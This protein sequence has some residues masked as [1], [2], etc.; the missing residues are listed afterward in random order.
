MA[1]DPTLD[2]SPAVRLELRHGGGRPVTYDVVGGE[3]L[4]GSVPGCDLRLSGTNLPPV[5]CVVSRHADGPHLRKLAPTLPLLLNGQPVQAAALRDGDTVTLGTLAIVVRVDV[6]AALTGGI[7]FEPVAAAPLPS[8]D[9]ERAELDKQRRQFEQQAADLEAD[10]AL[11]YR[12]REDIEREC[13]SREAQI[14]DLARQQDETDKVRNELTDLRRDL[15]ARYQE[16]RDR[17]AGLQQSVQTAARKVQEAKRTFEAEK[18]KAAPRLAELDRREQALADTREELELAKRAA[19]DEQRRREEAQREIE[20]RVVEREA[21]CVRKEQKCTEQE[22]RYQ[23]DLARMDRLQGTIEQ[24][25][26]Q[27]DA[28]SADIDAKSEQ[29]QRDTLEMEEQ[30]RQLD[31]AQVKLREAQEAMAARDA[32]VNDAAAKLAERA[33]LVEGQQSMLAALRTRLERMRDEVR[34]EATALAMSRAQHDAAAREVNEKLKTAEELK[35]TVEIESQ[36]QAAQRQQFEERSAA[37]QT[38]IGRMRELQDRLTAAEAATRERTAEIDVR[39]AD[40]DRQADELRVR[41]AQVF[42]QQ[43]KLDADRAAL[44]EREAALAQTEATRTAL[45]EQLR[46]RGEDLNAKQKQLD[47]QAQAIA[48]REANVGQSHESVGQFQREAE[49]KLTAAKVEL[50]Q[51]AAAIQQE[52]AAVAVRE[53]ALRRHVQRLKEAGQ[54]LAA[55]RKTY[56]ESKARHESEKALTGAELEKVRQELD[57]FREQTAREAAEVAKQLPD[58]ELRGSAVLERLAQAREQLRGH[59]G[60]LH[61][62]ARQSHDDLLMLRT[63]VQAESERLRQ[64]DVALQRARTEHRHAVTAFRQQLIDWQGRVV[65][66]RQVIAHDGTRLERQQAEVVAAAK[67]VDETTQQLAK[68]AADLQAQ[69]RVVVERRSEVERHLGDMRE[70]YRKK[71]R[72]LA[73]G[74]T[75]ALARSR[76]SADDNVPAVVPMPAASVATSHPNALATAED[77]GV[78][79]ITDDLD[80][81]DR[82]LGELLKSLELIDGDTLTALWL[83]ARRQRRSLRQVLLAGRAGGTPLLTLYQ[84]ALIEAGNLDALVLGRLRVVDRVRVTPRETVYRVFDPLRADLGGAALL[85][86]LSEAEVH[87]AVHPDEFRQRFAALA[88]VRHPHLAA[89]FEVTEINGR[90]AALQEWLSGLSSAEWPAAVAVAGVWYRL[91]TQAA[92][93][94]HT[95]H[96]AGLV[97]GSLGPRSVVLTAEGTV[98][99]CGVGEPAWL[100]GDAAEGTV[101]GDLAALGELAAAWSA[102]TPKRKGAKAPKPLP[103]PLQ[104][105]LSRLR[106]ASEVRIASAAELLD[107]LEKAGSDVPDAA[108]MW[109]KLIAFAGENATDGVA[110]RKSA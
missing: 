54:T 30:A 98:K 85:R 83:E 29:L 103:L 6:A 84:L 40:I 19:D 55:E 51:R 27:L 13:Q 89:T 71:M 59:L 104:A 22:A 33:A 43:Q 52:A 12:R 76:A 53:E 97:H 73:Q 99:L 24:R 37:L 75:A 48:Q 34:Q 61:T 36:A 58:L 95:A 100:N 78:L 14:T 10:R 35:S 86:H 32:E 41:A 4:I 11:W 105:V 91:V 57:A 64:Q 18:A 109:D 63:Q 62:Y 80:P 16:R 45:Q 17:L 56:F 108:E 72:E 65:E 101:E 70:W 47:E 28:R 67:H 8:F 102:A 90:P 50:E 26:R 3:F 74:D 1:H 81:G 42:E 25:E 66:M 21:E 94:L 23:S 69:E 9:S 106:P 82:K 68:Q 79:S 49:T 20:R 7:R 110:W 88:E 92:L 39:T 2:T 46:R 5:L 15:Y 77:E 87:D 60:E 93:G 96:Q 107:E 31:A 44:K 38:A